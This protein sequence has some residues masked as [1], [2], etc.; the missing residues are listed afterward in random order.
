[1]GELRARCQA[2]ASAGSKGD[3]KVSGGRTETA[4]G[5][6]AAQRGGHSG[7]QAR[8]CRPL[9]GLP[10]GRGRWCWKRQRHV[11]GIPG[12]KPSRPPAPRLPEID[13]IA[14]FIGHHRLKPAGSAQTPV[15]ITTRGRKRTRGAMNDTPMVVC[16]I[17][18]LRFGALS[19]HGDTEPTPPAPSVV[20]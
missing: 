1:M 3:G 5:E 14:A 19:V 6:E 7:G 11:H 18:V 16:G 17:C 12:V 10:G 8:A 13:D 4:G 15:P 2:S 20:G 9:P